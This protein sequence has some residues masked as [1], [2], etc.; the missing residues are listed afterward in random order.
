M[1]SFSNEQREN[2][3]ISPNN[4]FAVP[5]LKSDI[6]VLCTVLTAPLYLFSLRRSRPA[7]RYF[8]LWIYAAD[9]CFPSVFF[10]CP[11]YHAFSLVFRGTPVMDSAL[12]GAEHHGVGA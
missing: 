8:N 9:L 12:E 10:R 3:P 4:F 2:S 1:D 7:Q 5:S 6:Q 11:V